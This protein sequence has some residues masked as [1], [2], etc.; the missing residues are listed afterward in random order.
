[1]R[2]SAVDRQPDK[3]IPKPIC[4]GCGM[5]T[6]GRIKYAAFQPDCPKHGIITSYERNAENVVY[7]EGI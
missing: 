2:K 4:K 1:M 6:V 7:P 3:E 5:L